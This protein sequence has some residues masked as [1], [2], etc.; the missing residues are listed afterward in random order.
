MA[1][2]TGINQI[3]G[4][5]RLPA[6]TGPLPGREA[7]LT[8][9]IPI[10][11]GAR[12]TPERVIE[13]WK[14][15]AAS[16]NTAFPDKLLSIGILDNNAFPPIDNNGQQVTESSPS[17]VDVTNEI[18]NAGLSLYPGQFAVQW[19]GLN[20]VSLSPT[21]LTAASE[22]AIPGWQANPWLSTGTGDGTNYATPVT[23]THGTS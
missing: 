5:T 11:R 16:V 1:E 17:Y 2:I 23:P 22:G 6:A 9:T 21:G 10:G 13:A 18:I 3:T 15:L 14:S 7:E 8:N 20:S 12:C 4:E 19:N